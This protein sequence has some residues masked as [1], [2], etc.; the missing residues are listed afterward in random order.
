MLL[1]TGLLLLMSGH[2]QELLLGAIRFW[3]GDPSYVDPPRKL[4]LFIISSLG[5]GIMLLLYAALPS[6]QRGGVDRTFLKLID[7]RRAVII[8]AMLLLSCILLKVVIDENIVVQGERYWW[9]FDDAM[10]S[11]R[12]ARNLAD[13]EGL[14]WNPGERVEG[15]SN[16]L[17]T[18]YMAAVHLVSIPDSK[19]SLVVLLTNIALAVA[20]I[21]VLVRIVESLGGGS[22]ARA[23]TA[24]AYVLD[25]EVTGW[26]TTGLETS[27]L[28]LA[29]L[30]VLS[31]LLDEAEEGRVRPATYLLL[32]V[33][34]LIRAESIVHAAVLGGIALAINR[35]RKRVM[36]YGALA[37]LPTLLHVLVRVSYYGDPLPN[38]TY[39]KV[40]GWDDKYKSGLEY[41]IGFARIYLV[42][43]CVAVATAIRLPDLRIRLIVL[44]SLL[45]M[46]Y[47]V[48]I[49][50]DA[51]PSYRFFLPIV[52]LLLAV[53]FVGI[54][55]FSSRQG[56][57]LALTLL[58][59]ASLPII[60]RGD[61]KMIYPKRGSINNVVTG[62]LV[63]KNT[64]PDATVMDGFAGST[65]YFAQRYG[66]DYLGK[67][68]RYIA[69]LP[70]VAGNQPG[71]NKFDFDYSIGKLKPDVIIAA[72]GLPIDTMQMRRKLTE[73]WSPFKALM[74]YHPIFQEHC[75]PYPIN[76]Q[77]NRTIFIPD[78]SP[79]FQLRGQWTPVEWK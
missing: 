37:L 32:A 48:Y 69:H 54:E 56:V 30:W 70:V 22:M 79:L 11:M 26:A 7:S 9:L 17:W 66:I 38:T 50:G 3:K 35:D 75:L 19:T 1:A 42:P 33:I 45:M 55:R 27:L 65:L 23:A 46:G 57:R 16:L 49:G 62:L 63:K 20:T 68:D 5:I 34:P 47:V 76:V 14:V 15:Y 12:Y 10:I 73:T 52:P 41:V 13:G 78:W 77:L 44:A 4:I 67:C 74:Y 18:C 28:A 43:I 6:T 29:F 8:V 36:L 58:A 24:L 53:T 61:L 40:V 71:H 64:P 59:F 21:P 72:F 2:A 31:R 51:F 39:L 25:K 60:G